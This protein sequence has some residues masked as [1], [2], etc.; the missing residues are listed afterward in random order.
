MD[1]LRFDVAA[2][3]RVFDAAERAL[4]ELRTCM[5]P[6]GPDCMELEAA[7]RALEVVRTRALS[8]RRKYRHDPR[9][10]HPV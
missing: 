6:V 5:M 1:M 3:D 7:I 9:L 4:N 8:T 10:A 2:A